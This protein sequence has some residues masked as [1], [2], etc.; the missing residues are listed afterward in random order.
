MTA[1]EFTTELTDSGLLHIPTEAVARLPRAGRARVIILTADEGEDTEWRSEACT[2]F[3]RKD[4]PEDAV[5][6]HLR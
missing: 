4:P 2:Q 3:L 1:V 6:D 5:Y